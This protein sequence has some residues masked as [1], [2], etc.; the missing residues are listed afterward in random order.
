MSHG[1]LLN[2][3]LHGLKQLRRD[4][5]GQDMIE[6]ALLAAALVVI[7]A[8]FLP[9]QIIPAIS[10]VFSRIVISLNAS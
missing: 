1:K 3:L 9:P 6:Y 5:S 2:V 7:V 10:S 8:G 4:D